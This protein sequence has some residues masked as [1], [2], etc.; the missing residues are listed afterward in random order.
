M[1]ITHPGV[2]IV[3]VAADIFHFWPLKKS[4][5]GFIELLCELVKTGYDMLCLV[6]DAIKASLDTWV[7]ADVVHQVCKV[8]RQ[9]C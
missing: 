6:L 7:S 3:D 2:G 1:T 9:K 4:Y 8:K 5:T